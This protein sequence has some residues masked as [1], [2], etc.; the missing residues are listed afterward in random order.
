MAGE[1]TVTETVVAVNATTSPVQVTV[2]ETPVA[3][4]VTNQG[5]QGA[6]GASGVVAATSP[7]TYNSGT[8]TVGF[9]NTG[10]VRTTIAN[11]FTT[12][13]QLIKTGA[14]A[15]K[16]LILQRNSAT[17]TANLISVVQSDGTTEIARMR[18]NG[19]LG[20]GGLIT[21]TALALNT[22]LVGDNRA[23]VIKAG[24]TTPTNNA[25]ELLPLANNT[26]VMKV[27]FAGNITAPTFTGNVTGNV[28]GNA[29]TVT[30]G[31]YIAD[32]GVA[33]GVATL[34][35]S[36][37]I[38]T[39]Q[40]PPLAISDTFVVASQA[41]ML[42]LTAQVGDVAVRTDINQTFILQ[43]SP[44]TT[45]ANW[46]QIL[47]PPAITS[48]T[49]SSPLT[50]GTITST[51]TIGISDASTTVKGAVQLTDSTS[52]TSTTTAATPNSVKTVADSDALKAPLASPALTGTPTTTTAT[53]DTNTT[54]I[55]STA[56]VLGQASTTTPL[57][58]GTA[59]IGSATTYARANHIHPTDTTRAAVS[60]AT[61]TGQTSVQS[62][63]IS[64]VPLFVKPTGTVTFTGLS[65]SHSGGSGVLFD[66]ISGFSS[67]TGL[68]AGQSV[69]LS[70]FSNANFNGT[71][72]VTSVGTTTIQVTSL[73]ST[74]GTGT[75]GQA[76]VISTQANL[77]E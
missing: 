22:D 60:G 11:T 28:S 5:I 74:N 21:N 26:P 37:L 72:T 52:S 29:G 75:G 23:I 38:P 33:N 73:Q 69:T 13:A 40:L 76:Q 49:A 70:G 14:D 39:S 42:A 1:I 3:V 48:I 55:A 50:G 51:G 8:Q 77:Q 64:A 31:V 15:I 61:F 10:F 16:G 17:Q 45:L 30:N 32:K 56:F 58:D 66:N 7:I 57:V 34:D 65:A 6:T 47:T 63:S 44:P 2:T 9:D 46:I 54:Q 27:D 18:S 36:G 71:T 20:V 67:T 41:A 25:I 62:T 4:T 12:G 53:V 19:Q 43:A 24:Q 35:G 68:V 59:T